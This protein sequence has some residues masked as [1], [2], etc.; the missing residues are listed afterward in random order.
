[1]A[2]ADNL[3]QYDWIDGDGNTFNLSPDTSNERYLMEVSGL[4]LPGVERFVSKRP[5][6][7][8]QTKQGWRFTARAIDL[9]LAFRSA[10]PS[11]LWS[12][13]GDW[14]E[15]FNPELGTGTL[16]MVL[17]DGTERRIDC[18]VSDAIPL[19]SDQR[20]AGRIQI[21][22]IPLTADDPFLYNPSE[23]SASD[24]FDGVADVDITCVNSGNI[25]AW[26]TI[27]IEGEVVNPV[28][29]LVG[30]GETLTFTY[31]ISDGDTVTIDCENATVTLQDGTN[32]WQYLAKT[33]DV[34]KLA[35]G[36]NTVRITADSGTSTVTVK[37][38]EKYV[39]LSS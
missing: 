31:T 12:D 4:G 15:A 22:S 23:Q 7:H 10:S 3:I 35:R 2:I 17:Q 19:G 38:Y 9:V 24:D 33:D 18:D 16:K 27:E 8:G 32:L 29:E 30:S 5:Y 25:E 11:A 37:W 13:M 6:D 21:V 14:A 26:P 1:M 20:P 39:A 34:F 28:I 36:S